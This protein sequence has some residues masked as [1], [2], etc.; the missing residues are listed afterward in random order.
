LSRC[1][2]LLYPGTLTFWALEFLLL[3]F[4]NG[5]GQNKRFITFLADKLVYGHGN[6]PS[7]LN[8]SYGVKKRY[9]SLSLITFVQAKELVGSCFNQKFSPDGALIASNFS[10]KGHGHN[11]EPLKAHFSHA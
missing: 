10:L 3:I 6:P 8:K 7:N 11:A 1:N 2:L 4:L 5:Q 9:F